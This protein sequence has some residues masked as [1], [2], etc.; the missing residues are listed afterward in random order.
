MT[1][2]RR[3][4]YKVRSGT[5]RETENIAQDLLKA[6]LHV[7]LVYTALIYAQY[8]SEPVLDPSSMSKNSC[9]WWSLLSHGELRN[10]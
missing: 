2:C 7:Y 4:E 9:I 3:S 5:R 8:V 6:L 10:A 1:L